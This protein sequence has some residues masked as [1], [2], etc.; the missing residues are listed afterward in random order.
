MARKTMGIKSRVSL[1]NIRHRLTFK[2]FLTALLCSTI[3]VGLSSI[4]QVWLNFQAEKANIKE[5]LSFIEK[6]YLPSIAGSVYNLDE[7][8]IRLLLQG[9]LQLKG[10]EYSEVFYNF[11]EENLN[12]TEGIPKGFGNI[13]HE[14]PIRHQTRKGELINVGKLTVRA[15]YQS[16]WYHFGHLSPLSLLI[17]TFQIFLTALIMLIIFQFLVSRHLTTMARYARGLSFDN[18][19]SVLKLNRRTKPDEIE[20]VIGAINDLRERLKED[21]EKRSQQEV[22]LRHAYERFS[23][24]VDSLDAVVYVADMENHEILFANKHLRDLV[25]DIVGKTCWKVFQ[26]GPT[27]PCPFCSNKKLVDE[28]RNPTGIY[29]WEHL[30]SIN[31]RWY[32]CRDQ[33]IRWTDGRIVRLEVA[34]DITKRKQAE[35]QLQESEERYRFLVE[36]TAD[37]HFIC[38]YPSGSFIFLNQTMFALLIHTQES[39]KTLT[40]WDTIEKG[41]HEG[42]RKSIQGGGGK[43]PGIDSEVRNIIRRDGSKFRA[44]VSTSLVSYR[45]KVVLQGVLKDISEKEILMSQLQQAQKMEAIGHLAGGVAHDYNNMLAVILGYSELSLLSIDPKEPIYQNLLEISKAAV[46]SQSVTRQLLAFARKEAIQPQVLDINTA[47][48]SMLKMIRRLIGEDI[49][50]FWHPNPEIW[51]IRMDPSQIDQILANLCVNAKDAIVNTGKISIETSTITYDARYCAEHSGFIQGDFVVLTVTDNGIGMD[52]QTLEK[53]YDP[54]FTTKGVG[55][56]TGL[57]LSTVYGIAKQNKGFIKVHSEIGFGTSFQIHLPRYKGEILKRAEKIEK[58]IPMGKGEMV[59]VVEDEA[60]TL[61]MI[62]KFLPMLNYRCLSAHTPAEALRLAQIHTKD[63]SLLMTDVVMPEMNGR[64]LVEQLTGQIPQIKSLY[65]SG[66][67]AD[68]IGDRG[69]IREGVHF[70]QK[71]FSIKDLALKI[72]MVIDQ[73]SGESREPA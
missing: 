5:H 66:Y 23:R 71:P 53:I 31:G 34:T 27:G 21:I 67:T 55:K 72:K 51:P 38:E 20:M 6:S 57:G 60:S 15:G 73:P 18:L 62:E 19:E 2:V 22:E 45:D 43:A 1:M 30:N 50:F 3:F 49:D 42:L 69:V 54:F 40:I 8:Q 70:I 10:I 65:M 39:A 29:L 17:N 26:S 28:H 56:G 63:I 24:V 61:K 46:R 7:P 33:A 16:F 59:L 58:E 52:K 4:L 47:I 41:D 37:G 12:I 35:K 36:N 14:Y 44:E 13:V 32:E 64:E 9:V 11:G 68:E 25:G 48:E